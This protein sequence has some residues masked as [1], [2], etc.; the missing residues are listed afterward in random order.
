MLCSK[1]GFDVAIEIQLA[2][3]DRYLILKTT[4]HCGEPSVGPVANFKRNIFP[5]R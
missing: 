4:S 2:D 5:F 1:G 3:L